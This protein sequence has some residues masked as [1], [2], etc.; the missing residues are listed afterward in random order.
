MIVFMADELL[1]EL[2]WRKALDDERDGK[3]GAYP[4]ALL[5]VIA[6]V[7]VAGPGVIMTLLWLA[8]R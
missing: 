1:A 8:L 5:G 7:V 3:C 2:E 4:L 6:G